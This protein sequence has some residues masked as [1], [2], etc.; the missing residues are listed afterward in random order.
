MLEQELITIHF[1]LSKHKLDRKHHRKIG[2]RAKYYQNTISQS[3][4][5]RSNLDIHGN[6]K[7]ITYKN[8]LKENGI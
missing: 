2:S 7:S 3:S 5:R 8:P 4:G 6:G 1:D